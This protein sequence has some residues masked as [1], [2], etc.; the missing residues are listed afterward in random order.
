MIQIIFV[1]GTFGSTIE[2]FIR[3]FTKDP[4]LESFKIADD[5]STHIYSLPHHFT[6]K[7]NLDEFLENYNTF[8]S[9]EI[10]STIYPMANFCT[11]SII[12][13]FKNKQFFSDT[14]VLINIKSI[15]DGEMVLLFKYYKLANGKIQ[16]QT[17]S[18]FLQELKNHLN[19]LN[20]NYKD[21]DDVPIWAVRE[22]FSLYYPEFINTWINAKIDIPN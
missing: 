20:E 22:W 9:D 2:Q 3:C 10:V 8:N 18:M 16:K 11:N 12:D 13:F 21:V 15:E 5:G 4:S 14:K 17:N 1:P 19:K 6:S 7:Q